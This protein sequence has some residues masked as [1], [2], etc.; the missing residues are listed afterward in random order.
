M[1]AGYYAR[2][3]GGDA[4]CRALREPRVDGNPH[5][6]FTRMV[7]DRWALDEPNRIRLLSACDTRL[8]WLL[9]EAEAQGDEEMELLTSVRAQHCRERGE[10]DTDLLADAGLFLGIPASLPFRYMDK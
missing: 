3:T 4:L 8:G 5:H 2:K 7:L 10:C 9:E 6:R 1:A